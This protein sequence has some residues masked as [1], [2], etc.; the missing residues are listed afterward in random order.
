M[1]D[2]DARDTDVLVVGAGPGGVSAALEAARAGASVVIADATGEVGGNGAFSTGYIAFADSDYQRDHGVADDADKF[3]SDMLREVELQR[4]EFDPEFDADLAHRFARESRDAYSFLS[5]LGFRFS[6][7]IPRPLQH[8]TPRMLATVDPSRFNAGFSE[9]FDDL[10]VERLL[11]RP[12]VALTTTGDRVTGARIGGGAHEIE[13]RARLGVVIGAGGFQA[14]PDLRRRYQP[15][16]DPYSPYAGLDTAKGDGQQMM[17][18]VGADLVNMTLIPRHICA[19]SRFIEDSIALNGDGHRFHDEAGP[20]DDRVTALQSE[21]GV[22]GYYFCDAL[23]A[24]RNAQHIA[25]MPR[26]AKHFNSLAEVASAIGAEPESVIETVD[27]WN[28][29]LASGVDKDP[30]FDRVVFPAD[31]AAITTLPYSVIPMVMGTTFTAG[32]ARVTI[33]MEVLRPDRTVIP[34]LFAVGDSV[35]M[36]NPAS[37]LGGM[38]LSSGVTLGRVAGRNVVQG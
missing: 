35:G 36:I 29:M 17:E 14:N 1:S 16:Q 22:I 38:H 4:E 15:G 7:L 18:S 20:Y 11:R 23:A 21:P 28:A 10:G 3:V 30:E 5:E 26:P 9:A 8:T 37:G 31:R 25:E 32:G 24:S 6:R 34:G 33:D 19:A 27:R 12:V 13:V 2:P